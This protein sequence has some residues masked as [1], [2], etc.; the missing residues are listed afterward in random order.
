M[1]EYVTKKFDLDKID[2]RDENSKYPYETT[3]VGVGFL[4]RKPTGGIS[5]RTSAFNKKSEK[6]FVNRTTT[7][8]EDGE[9]APGAKDGASKENPF[10][11]VIRVK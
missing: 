11:W 7:N 1:D 6:L 10:T 5:G 3:E 8:P 9:S 2:V 4:V